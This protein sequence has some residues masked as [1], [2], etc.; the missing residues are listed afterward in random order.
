MIGKSGDG[1]REGGLGDVHDHLLAAKERI[2]DEF[3]GAQRD[4]L[5]AVCHNCGLVVAIGVTA[6]VDR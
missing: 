4:R 1:D 5:L 3:A 2:A 6:P